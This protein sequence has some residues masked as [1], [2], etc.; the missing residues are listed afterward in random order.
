MKI[1]TWQRITDEVTGISC[2]IGR[3]TY[4]EKPEVAVLVGQVWGKIH[5]FQKEHGGSD[6]EV[7]ASKVSPEDQVT[8]LR[9]A[10]SALREKD[11][12]VA[13]IFREKVRNVAELE[14]ERGSITTGERLKEV[15]DE[16][17]LMWILGALLNRASLT[18]AE[19]KASGSPSTSS[20]PGTAASSS[21]ASSTGAAS[22]TTPSTAPAILPVKVSSSREA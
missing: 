16:H 17:I 21:A 5:R 13:G 1:A 15:A 14:D 18:D 9:D 3:L 8:V 12:F 20:I 4:L 22:G 19:G 11:D 2:E 10:Y 7:D 6:G